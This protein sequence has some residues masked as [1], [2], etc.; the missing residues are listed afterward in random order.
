MRLVPFAADPKDRSPCAQHGCV[1]P[2]LW[3]AVPDAGMGHTGNERLALYCRRH[4][5]WVA[6]QY[7]RIRCEEW[8]I[9]P[10]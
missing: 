1:H 2:P 8:E 7:Q 4:V 5:L 9:E 6:E 3:Q 10:L